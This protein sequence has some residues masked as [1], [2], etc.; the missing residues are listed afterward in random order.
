[1]AADNGHLL[2]AENRGG[3][4]WPPGMGVNESGKLSSVLYHNFMQC[5]G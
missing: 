5:K 4:Y 3:L 2:D 1:M